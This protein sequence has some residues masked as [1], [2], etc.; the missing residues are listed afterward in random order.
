MV[1]GRGLAGLIRERFGL[2]ILWPA[3]LLL[4]VA[5]VSNIAADLGAMAASPR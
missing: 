2:W 3:C 5:N 1:T 4:T